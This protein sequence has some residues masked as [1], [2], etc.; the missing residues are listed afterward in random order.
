MDLNLSLRKGGF[1]ADQ[2]SKQEVIRATLQSKRDDENFP[3][4]GD[5]KQSIC[6]AVKQIIGPINHSSDKENSRAQHLNLG[7]S[8]TLLLSS[9]SLNLEEIN[10]SA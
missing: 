4:R 7:M 9:Y 6:F 2:Q 1:V 3:L 10:P 8:K 5:Q